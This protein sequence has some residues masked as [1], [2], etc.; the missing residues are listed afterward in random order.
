MNFGSLRKKDM[1]KTHTGVRVF[2]NQHLDSGMG[3]SRTGVGVF[4]GPSLYNN[5]DSKTGVFVSQSVVF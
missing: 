3:K 2:E 1:T 4:L 5:Q